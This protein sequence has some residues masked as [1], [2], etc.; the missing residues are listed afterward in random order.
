MQ[1]FLIKCI[2]CLLLGTIL[3]GIPFGG[4]LGVECAMAHGYLNF[5][6]LK[7][8]LLWLQQRL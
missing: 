3:I 4:L 5:H 8:M 1:R 7:Q 6:W 2:N